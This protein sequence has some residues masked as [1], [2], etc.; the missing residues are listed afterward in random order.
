MQKLTV[1]NAAAEL[2]KVAGKPVLYISWGE[3]FLLPDVV[4][5]APYLLADDDFQYQVG[6][7]AII[8][9]DDE[10]EMDRLYD[11]TV[12]DDGPTE[13]NPY[14]GP[15]SVYALTINAKGEFQRENT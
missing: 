7:T 12:G 6:K 11:M 4:K 13:L 10:E 14:D 2:A 1:L 15:V 5:A 9:C 8:L 3:D